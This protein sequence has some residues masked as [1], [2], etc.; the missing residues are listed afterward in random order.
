V[1]R[2]SPDRNRYADPKEGTWQRK[3]M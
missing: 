3:R 2:E 1:N